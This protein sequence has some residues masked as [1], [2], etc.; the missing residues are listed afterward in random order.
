MISAGRLLLAASVLGTCLLASFAATS[1]QVRAAAKRPLPAP[2]SFR[3]QASN[4]YTLYVMGVSGRG[5]REGFVMVHA[6]ARG[7]S[8]TY[9]VPATVTETSIQADLG[10]V[11]QIAVAFQ[12]TGRAVRIPCRGQKIAFDSG[13]YEGVVAFHG[14]EGYTAVDVTSVPGDARQWLDGICDGGW[15]FEVF[16]GRPRGARLKVRNPA[17]GQEMSVH[18]SRPDAAGGITAWTREYTSNRISIERRVGMR[19]PSAAFT[20]DRRLR[21]ATVRPA[22]PF[23]GSAHFDR[24][25]KAGQRWSGNLTVDLP[26]KSDLPLTGPSLRA[27]LVP[28][29]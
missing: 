16:A 20:Y 6:F 25:K 22:A 17:L 24:R 13:T 2:G 15:S 27:N 19:I 26:G 9:T 11:G 4:G 21:T 3:I 5:D 28:S 23:S 7:K 10:P 29:E 1:T 18:K 14:E 8:V 12:R